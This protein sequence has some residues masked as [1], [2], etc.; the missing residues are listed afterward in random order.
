MRA[1]PAAAVT[2]V[3]AAAAGISVALA[4]AIP[5][6][7]PANPITSVGSLVIDF[8]PPAIKD[9]VIALFGTGDKPFLIAV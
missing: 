3:C 8:T 6:G 4:S 2:G 1:T 9:T 7:E 5:L